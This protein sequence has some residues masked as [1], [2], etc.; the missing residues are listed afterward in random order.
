MRT[1]RLFPF[2]LLA[3]C[4]GRG[5][6]ESAVQDSSMDFAHATPAPAAAPA[7]QGIATREVAHRS[8]GKGVTSVAASGA[9]S[10]GSALPAGA[11]LQQSSAIIRT[12]NASVEVPELD[13]A[14]ARVRRLASAL[15]GYVANTSLQG[16]ADEVASAVVELKLPAGRFDEAIAGLD[17]VGDVES[18]SVEAQDVGEELVDLEARVANAR[19]LETRLVELLATRTGR[20]EDVLAVERELARVREEIERLEGRLRYLRTRVAVST[21]VVSLHEPRPILGQT[22]NPIAEAVRDAWRN[23]VATV[24]M[25]IA[26]LGAL[27][28]VAV[29]VAA[30]VMIVQRVQRVLRRRYAMNR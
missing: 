10:A 19:R 7:P 26:G 28:P 27:V 17:P 29:V 5:S 22:D 16:G 9:A 8:L 14:V 1:L 15:G 12:G 20:L 24:A 4:S 3:A 21:L 2:I 30:T 23:F 13:T 11:S 18:V 6:D 25:M